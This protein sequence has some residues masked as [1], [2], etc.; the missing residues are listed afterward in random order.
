MKNLT[1]GGW[2]LISLLSAGCGSSRQTESSSATAPVKALWQSQPLYIDGSDNDWVRPLPY[3][4][5]EEYVSY[6]ISNDEKNLYILVT[7]ASRQ[8]QQKIIEG[9]MSVWVNTKGD[10]SNGDAVGIGYPLN[11]QND[12]DRQLMQEAQ[13]QRYQNKTVRLE[14]RHTY[15]LY[16]FNKDTTIRSYTYGEKNPVGV[17]MRMDYNNHGD[18]VY[19]AAVPLQSL[20]PE[21]TPGT[22]FSTGNLA[23]GIF[24]EPL[25]SGARVQRGGGGGSG[26][27]FGIGTGFGGFGSGVGMGMSIGHEFGAGGRRPNRTLFDEAQ[28][29]Q[30][31]RLAQK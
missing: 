14:D 26:P 19:E 11:E 16:G 28:I 9:G 27:G 12:R 18:I 30:V 23:V 7:T 3:S 5:K 21:H 10:R 22:P 24:I 1:L 31:V 8:E 25:P 2:A 17:N 20:Y 4:I 29:W 15:A 6:S 13:P